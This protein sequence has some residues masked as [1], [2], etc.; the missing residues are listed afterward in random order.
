M[1]W[2]RPVAVVLRLI[3]RCVTGVVGGVEWLTRKTA[4]RV[5][6][7]RDRGGAGDT[8]MI[9]L[10]DLH[11]ASCAGDALVAIGLAGTIFFAGATS[12]ART[13]VALYLLV[14]MAPFAVLAPVVGPLLDRFRHGR[15]YALAVTFLGRAFLAWVISDQMNTIALYPAAFGVLVLSRS[16][17]V[18]RSAAV[19]RLL[20]RRL[21]LVEAGAR[22]SL[23]GTVAGGV[24]GAIG[25]ALAWLGPQWPLRL[26]TVVFVF[27]MVVALRLPPKADSEPPETPPRIFQVFRSVGVKVLTG[28]LVWAALA[29]SATLRA[30]Y[31]FLTLFFA[32][33]I[34]EGDFALRIAGYRLPQTALLALVVGGLGAGSFL[35]TAVCTRL[36]IRRP[37]LLQA[38]GLALT[39]LAGL[40]ATLWYTAWTAAVLCLLTAF[41]SG[42]A[43]LSVDAIIQ[44]RIGEKLRASAFSHSETLLML[45]FVFGVDVDKV[46]HGFTASQRADREHK[47]RLAEGG[48]RPE[49]VC[50]SD[51][52]QDAVCY[53]TSH[54]VEYQHSLPVARL[55]INGTTLCTAW[56]VTADDR[57]LTNHHCI[58]DQAD[59]SNTEVWFNYQCSSCGG[60]EIAPVTKVPADKLLRTDETLDYSL[61]SVSDFASIKHFGYLGLDIR[62]PKAGEQVYIPQHPEGDPTKL[63][64]ASDGENGATCRI[65]EA[66]IDG[67]ASNSDTGYRCD[68][69]PGASGSPVI[70]RSTNRVIALHH[71]GGCPNS[72]VRIDL[73]YPQIKSLL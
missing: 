64:I 9:R 20:P 12:D 25:V 17:G 36:T 41:C 51:D 40:A 19:P 73:I 11:A 29:G 46:A 57:M 31:G 60:S 35:A 53:K 1:S 50:G 59:T 33:R 70:A 62:K 8:G 24:I 3:V 13:K 6:S 16:Y 69:A 2:L 32:F 7:A 30:G 65:D 39:G 44:E 5:R 68:T 56:R 72:G 66:T 27:G 34:R 37:L 23:F 26:A 18:A 55:L 43:K 4:G 22:A 14:T 28:R 47:E 49:S 67:Y 48:R 63:A 71:L 58:G 54:P 21:G 45:A 15:R 10:L 42:V 38:I 52:A 61:F